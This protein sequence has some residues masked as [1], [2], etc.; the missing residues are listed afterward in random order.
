MSC[1]TCDNTVIRFVCF[2]NRILTRW[3]FDLSDVKSGWKEVM[4]FGIGSLP[5]ES[6]VSCPL[7]SVVEDSVV[8][9]DIN[10]RRAPGYRLAFYNDEILT[11]ATQFERVTHKI[12]TS[13]SCF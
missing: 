13:S 7:L 2:E 6:W 9:V 5:P 1:S 8:Y 10:S 11:V 12:V 4:S 3:T